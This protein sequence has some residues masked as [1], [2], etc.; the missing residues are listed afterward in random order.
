MIRTML[1]HLLG[2]DP[3]A[4]LLHESPRGALSLDPAHHSTDLCFNLSHTDGLVVLAIARQPVGVDVEWLDRRGR[5]I[6]LAD[7]YFAPTE[8]TALRA[9]PETAQ[10]DRFFDL[11]TLKEAYI[12]ARG[13]GLA[14]PLG[15]FAYSDFETPPLSIAVDPTLADRPDSEWSF[16]TWDRP[17]TRHRV[18]AALVSS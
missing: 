3:A 10:R 5:T 14:L 18:A 1:G 6:E 12:K 9:L 2:A 15:G 7:R 8:I 4:V 16:G 11:W 13:L 17:D